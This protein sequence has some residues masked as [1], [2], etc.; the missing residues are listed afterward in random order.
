MFSESL[1]SFLQNVENAICSCRG[2]YGYI[3]PFCCSFLIFEKSVDNES[4]RVFPLFGLV[5]D[6]SQKFAF[7]TY[8]FNLTS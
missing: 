4:F 6:H 1:R 7:S 8:W 5:L 3:K 2:V